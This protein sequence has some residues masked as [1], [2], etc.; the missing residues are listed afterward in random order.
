M[1]S[2]CWAYTPER[3]STATLPREFSVCHANAQVDTDDG[4]NGG[5][6]LT[7][8]ANGA[9]VKHPVFDIGNPNEAEMFARVKVSTLPSVE[10]ILLGVTDSDLNVLAC[11]TVLPSGQVAVYQGEMASLLGV[12]EDAITT[13]TQLRLGFVAALKETGSI[14]LMLDDVILASATGMS[15][16]PEWAGVYIGCHQ[17]IYISHIH[18]ADDLMARPDWLCDATPSSHANLDD[19]DNDGDT[20]VVAL[21]E[22]DQYASPLGTVTSRRLVYG[23]SWRA[24]VKAIDAPHGYR[25]RI[26]VNGEPTLLPRRPVGTADYQAI[27][28]GLILNPSTG[29]PF[30]TTDVDDDLELGGRAV[31]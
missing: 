26:L 30:T 9:Y 6:A 12:S 17:N 8:S 3:V 19:T 2:M 21:G 18:A 27:D 24:S 22:D 23:V 25:P 11:L 28:A 13:A 10:S 4:Y 5:K 1:A 20:T 16:L 31:L 15:L 14:D 7:A 29:L